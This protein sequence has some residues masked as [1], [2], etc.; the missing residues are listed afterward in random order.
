MRRPLPLLRPAV[1]GLV[2][3][4]P[5]SAL[6]STRDDRVTTLV[7]TSAIVASAVLVAA[8]RSVGET[9][10]EQPGRVATL[11]ALTLVLQLFSVRVYG[12]G[13]VSVSAIG[14]LAS[15]FLVDTGTAMAIA[16]VAALAHSVR[17]RAQPH[18]AIF[19]AAN[20]ALS[21]AVA[22]TVFQAADSWR[23]GAAVLAGFVFAALHNGLLCLAMSLAESASWRTI[24]V[25]RFPRA[26][27]HLALFGPVALRAAI[28]VE[29]TRD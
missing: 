26:R 15:V 4:E 10:A 18:K 23:P 9:V 25:E 5:S 12:R 20:F 24:W 14:M 1:S 27:Y 16:V 3:I 8:A 17:R 19:D 6:G 22:S 21:T 28:A 7:V 29:Q 2:R 13:S 11:L